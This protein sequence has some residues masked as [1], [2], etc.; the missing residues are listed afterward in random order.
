MGDR[1]LLLR[2]VRGREDQAFGFLP[3]FAPF[4]FRSRRL[5]ARLLMGLSF[6][7]SVMLTR[8]SA[9]QRPP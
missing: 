2:P 4:F 9:W 1:P 7:R 6:N 8:R 5:R 3:W